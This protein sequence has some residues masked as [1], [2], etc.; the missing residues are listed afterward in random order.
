MVSSEKGN[1]RKLL[2]RSRFKVQPLKVAKSFSE[3][4]KPLLGFAVSVSCY[5][6]SRAALFWDTERVH[7][8]ALLFFVVSSD[9][10]AKAWVGTMSDE[11]TIWSLAQFHL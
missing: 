1:L 4:E 5:Q 11:L 3:L 10:C 8:V 6:T 9:F 2:F 7:S